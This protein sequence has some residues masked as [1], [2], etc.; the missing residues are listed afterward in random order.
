MLRKALAMAAALTIAGG[1]IASADPLV[2]TLPELSGPHAV[3]VVDL[4]LVD[5]SRPDP[6]NP[7]LP[8][9]DVVVSVFYPAAKVR[10]YPLAPEMSERAAT[11]FA[12][13][14]IG[15][16]HP[17]FPHEAQQGVSWKDIR[18]HAHV[19]A[20]GLPGRRPVLLYSPGLVDPRTIGA[21]LAEDLASRGYVVVTIDHPGETSE[22]DIPGGEVRDFGLNGIP[23]LDPALY[24]RVMATRLADTRFV[25]DSL[26][27]LPLP[28]G[29]ALDPRRIGMYGQGSGGSTAAEAMFEDRRIDAAVNLEGFLDYHPETVGGEGEL[30]PVAACGVDRPLLLWGSSGFQNARYDRAWSA[31]QARSRSVRRQVMADAGHWVFT[32][33]GSVVP[34]VQAAGLISAEGRVSLVGAVSPGRSVREVRDGVAGFFDRHLRS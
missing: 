26:R 21:S 3:G 4:H 14:D 13:L 11:R 17:Q 10:G 18:T 16:L 27:D 9:R 31:V 28:R 2:P 5:R 30:L 12:S 34:Q 29:V 22:V 6:W 24:R 19:G 1:G 33:F 32:D 25:L 7:A 8:V 15:I 23:S 20:P